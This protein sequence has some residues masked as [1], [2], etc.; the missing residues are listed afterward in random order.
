MGT[1]I[2]SEIKFPNNS[3]DKKNN[4]NETV[5]DHY[6]KI[7]DSLVAGAKDH[8]EM[9][10]KSEIKKKSKSEMTKMNVND[11][12]KKIEEEASRIVAKKEEEMHKNSMNDRVKLESLSTKTNKKMK[13]N[14]G[15]K[16]NKDK[17][18]TKAKK[19]NKNIQP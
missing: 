14:K 16:A 7:D 19:D 13:K 6:M 10:V 17:K 15:T 2:K 5:F 12:M 8:R 18:E 1:T 9:P 11:M 3:D 4:K